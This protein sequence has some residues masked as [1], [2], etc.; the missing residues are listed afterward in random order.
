MPDELR[1]VTQIFYAPDA[2]HPEAHQAR[3]LA[4][5]GPLA[6]ASY[7]VGAQPIMLGRAT[8]NKIC[9]VSA[10]VSKEHC[11]LSR[12]EHGV[13]HI[14][15][16]ASKNGTFLNGKRLSAQEQVAL[17]HG[18]TVLVCDSEFLFLN[19]V[20]EESTIIDLAL[21]QAEVRAEAHSFMESF[22]ELAALSKE[23]RRRT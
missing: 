22:A 5:S 7:L 1:S 17:T 13:F 8:V 9:L 14:Q 21:D 11:G 6:G 3:L 15:D 4:V 18:D 23:R 2:S 12:D 20:D 16:Q 19:P 10:G